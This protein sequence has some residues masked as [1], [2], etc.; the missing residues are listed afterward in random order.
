MGISR[1]NK[2]FAQKVAQSAALS[3]LAQTISMALVLEPALADEPVFKVPSLSGEASASSVKSE[4]DAATTDGAGLENKNLTVEDVTIE[5][6][7]LVPTDHILNVV[8]TKRGDKFDRDQIVQ[9]LKAVNNMGYFDDRSLQALPELSG[10]GVLLKIRVQENA[11]VTEFAFQGNTVMSNEELSKLFTDQL[12]KPQNLTQLSQSI[13]KVEQSYHEKGFTLA[14]VVDVKDDPDGSVHLQI[15]EGVINSVQIVGNKKTKDFIIRNAIKMKP[16]AVYNEKMLTGDLRKL[17]SNGYFQDIRR[18]LSPSNSD[19]DK[20]DLKVEVD[21]KRT[22]SIG[23]GGGVDA[24]AGPFGSASFSDSNFR[25]RGQIVNFS[26]QM[27]SGLFGS[28]TNAVNNGGNNFIPNSRTYQVEASYIDPNFRG[29]NTSLAVTPFARNLGS[30]IVDNSM[31]RTTGINVNFTRKLSERVSA[32]LG[33]LGENASLKSVENLTM[34]SGIVQRA[35]Q[36]GQANSANA[37][38]YANSVR[39]QALKGGT[40]IGVNPSIAYDT[41]DQIF[42]PQK[43]TMARLSVGPNMA[44]SGNSFLKTGASVSKYIPVGKD[45]TIAFNVQGGAGLGGMPQ[46]AAFNMGGF[47]GI[48]G[49]RMFSDLGTGTSMLMATAEFRMPLPLPAGS[50][51]SKSGAI[52]NGIHKNVKLVF[53]GD[54]GG[55]G[56]NSL[57]NSLYSRSNM[58]A[59]VGLGMRMKVPYLGLVRVDY[60]L[61]LVAPLMGGKMIPRLT[62][63]FGDKFQ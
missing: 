24:V 40:Y 25:G 26:S 15:D 32:N 62:F 27:G 61:P 39:N 16:G 11:P 5:G 23:M 45:K 51:S 34:E 48:R 28:F 7:R 53:F 33:L 36:L 43:G 8:K 37:L 63:G 60:G 14:R 47:N 17:Y 56:G 38:N 46:F 29:T 20:Y 19:P 59:S 10:G 31:Q 3:L 50:P 55:V 52:L 30:M 58:G 41:R 57:Y 44:L 1:G 4:S 2:I 9:D 21:E 22:G 49:Y 13:D 6:N 35:M 12:G 18:S 54:V 42:D